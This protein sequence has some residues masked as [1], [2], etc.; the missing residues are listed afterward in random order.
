MWGGSLWHGPAEQW[1]SWSSCCPD[2]GHAVQC[3]ETL[4]ALLT[5]LVYF[6]PRSMALCHATYSLHHTTPPHTHTYTQSLPLLH[7]RTSINSRS[8]QS[9]CSEKKGKLTIANTYTQERDRQ[10]TAW[11]N[12]FRKGAVGPFVTWG[13]AIQI[14][15]KTWGKIK[16]VI[17]TSKEKSG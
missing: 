13:N 6:S 1:S 10:M 14:V 12:I 7:Y 3:S 5:A 8:L 4:P 11:K 17:L 15:N 2:Q 16:E 9:L